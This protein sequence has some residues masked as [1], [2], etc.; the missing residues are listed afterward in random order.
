MRSESACSSGC[1]RPLSFRDVLERELDFVWAC[2]HRLGIA[3][4]DLEGAVLD[5]F[6]RVKG[7]LADLDPTR[8]LQPWLAGFAYRVALEYR[9]SPDNG[10]AKRNFDVDAGAPSV[11]G[12]DCGGA[13]DDRAVLSGALQKLDLERRA[14]FVLHVIH[15]YSISEVAEICKMPI[16][17]AQARQ[18]L[19][20]A[21]LIQILNRAGWRGEG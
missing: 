19:A 2:L 11:S 5:V 12:Q 15:G 13:G 3:E 9:S 6:S 4:E 14:V 10:L 18:W 7:E 16:D 17:L 1:A 21:E 20:C 8:R